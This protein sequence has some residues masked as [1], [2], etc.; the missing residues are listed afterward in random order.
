MDKSSD[1]QWTDPKILSNALVVY[2]Y[3]MENRNT[4]MTPDKARDKKN[5]LEVKMNLEMNKVKKRKYPE[6]EVGSNV[7]IYTKKKN[8]KKERV[9]VWSDLIYEV[10]EITENF[11]QNTSL[12]I[13][14]SECSNYLYT[15]EIL[16]FFSKSIIL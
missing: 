4:K 5:T 6:I 16:F 13:N 15:G 14:L 11:N 1:S 9:S 2:N 7:R 12:K 3:R 10:E 8:F